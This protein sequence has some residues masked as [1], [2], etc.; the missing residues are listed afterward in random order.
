MVSDRTGVGLGVAL[1]VPDVRGDA[2][3]APAGLSGHEGEADRLPRRA[4]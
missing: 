2:C 1:H 3:T 4:C